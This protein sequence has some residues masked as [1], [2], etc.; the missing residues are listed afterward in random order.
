MAGYKRSQGDR[1]PTLDLNRKRFR[2]LVAARGWTTQLEQAAALGIAQNTLSRI[3]ESEGRPG[4]RVIAAL[5]IA[6]PDEP[7]DDLFEIVEDLPLRRV[8]A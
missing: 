6:F 8:A 3:V 7:F 5:L 1:P 4:T 2:E